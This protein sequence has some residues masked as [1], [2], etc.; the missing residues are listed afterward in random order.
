MADVEI[1]AACD[2]SLERARTVSTGAFSSAEELFASI[3]LDF[4]D[5]ATR[6]ESHLE[7]VRLGANRRVDMICQKPMA[8]DLA[9]AAEMLA[10]ATRSGARLMIHDNWRWQ[11]WHRRVADFIQAG[12]IGQPF[13]YG[14]RT[15]KRDGTGP[16]PYA[17]QPYFRHMPRFLI[18]EVLVHHIDV[19]RFLFGEIASVYALASRRNEAIAGE[20]QALVMIR[21]SS[22][23]DGWVDGHRY[24]DMR[25]ENTVMGDAFFD[26]DEGMLEVSPSGDVLCNGTL[27]WKNDVTNGYRGDSVYATQKHFIE[28]LR[29]GGVFET[30]AA[31][32]LRSFGAAEAAYTSISEERPVQL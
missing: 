23:V 15:R 16:Q 12:Q 10:V 6:P 3:E 32:Y 26:G 30:D 17:A 27:A 7:I 28:C 2:P 18:Y 31:D 24:L 11:P 19:A 29:S 5:I 20:D 1:V 9:Q 25:P 13:G 8:V 21:H 22:G 4:V 14:F